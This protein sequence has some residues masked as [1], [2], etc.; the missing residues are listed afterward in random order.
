[1]NVGELYFEMGTRGDI[2]RE[3]DQAETAATNLA[4]QAGR[5]EQALANIAAPESLRR[6]IMQA[7]DAVGQLSTSAGTART[8]IRQLSGSFDSAARREARQTADAVEQVAR[9][10]QSA[11]GE[12]RQLTGS[13]A[14]AEQRAAGVGNAF[15]ESMEG[16]GEAG[17][18]GGAAGGGG[19]IAMFASK[20]KGAAGKGG[21]IAAAVTA[22]VAVGVVA[23]QKLADAVQEG[24]ALQAERDF[25]QASFGFTDAQMDQAGKAA[26]DAFGNAFGTSVNENI[27]T[28]GIAI[29]AGIL[30]GDATAAEMQPIIEQL[31]FTSELM[32]EEIPAV[33]KA[34]GQWIRTGLVKNGVEAFDL[35]TAAQQRGLNLSEDILDTMNEYGTHFRKAGIDGATAMGL[36]AQAV[37]GGARDTDI[38]ADAIKEFALRVIDTGEATTEALGAM[39]GTIGM[40]VEEIQGEFAK[41][42]EAAFNMTDKILD[43]LGEL[44][45]EVDKNA[46]AIALFGTQYEDLG[47]AFDEF[48]LTTARDE[49]DASGKSLEAMGTAGGGAA[50]SIQGAKS[51]I[52]V[53][54]DEMKIKLGEA[55]AP[56]AGDAANWVTEHEGEILQFLATVATTAL[57][58]TAGLLDAG[59]AALQFGALAYSA[60]LEI[61]DG[62]VGP[63]T[64]MMESLGGVLKHVPGM[65]SVGGAMEDTARKTRGLVEGMRDG[66]DK[67][68]DAGGA[69]FTLADKVRDGKATIEDYALA[70]QEAAAGTDV[71]KQEVADLSYEL[72][73]LPR[74]HNI[75]MDAPG[76][77]AVVD[78]LTGLGVQV[79]TDNRKEVEVI[80]PLAPGV[81]DL[82]KQLGVEVVS[83]NGKDILVTT[84]APAAKTEVDALNQSIDNMTT[85]KQVLFDLVLNKPPAPYTGT[86]NGAT[87]GVLGAFPNANRWGSIRGVQQFKDGG[88]TAD[89]MKKP[90][91][92]DIYQPRPGHVSIFN[93]ESTKGETYLPWDQAARARSIAIMKATAQAWGLDVVPAGMV[94]GP[95][96][97]GVRADGAI[98]TPSQV[99]GA[100]GGLSSGVYSFGGW[101]GTWNTDCSGAQAKAANW[102]TAG[103]TEAGGRFATGNMAEALGARGYTAGQAPAGVPAIEH[104]WYNGGEGGGHAA[105]TVYDP[106][107]GDTDFEMGG[108][109]GNGAVGAGASGSREIGADN[110]A[111][112]PLGSEDPRATGGGSM[113]TQSQVGGGASS[114]PKIGVNG[115]SDSGAALNVNVM[116]WPA[117]LTGGGAKA[118]LGVAMYNTGGTIAG[119]GDS[120]TELFLGTPGEEIIAKGPASKPGMRAH[121]KAI[122]SG[123]VSM[124]STGGTVGGFGGYTSS[125]AEHHKDWNLYDLLAAGTG[126]AFTA[127]SAVNVQ[128]GQLKGFNGF[129]TGST[130]IPGSDDLYKLLKEQAEKPTIVIEHAEINADSPQELA[131]SLLAINPATAEMTKRGIL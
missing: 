26:G 34:A 72:N 47:A 58:V 119:A 60:G 63:L 64:T 28:A 50:A 21:P 48:D 31:Q 37:E 121:L 127:A 54:A 49:M 4:R 41:G 56:M 36:I 125:G 15:R 20:L 14:T 109:S 45:P 40:S 11:V 13:F 62:F 74:E 111:W 39:S 108:S 94:G 129:S 96:D 7:D 89:W 16:A 67:M 57:E 112:K 53:A 76:G 105:G 42:G 61:L 93:E 100:I 88:I 98:V 114:A 83:N 120:D 90:K 126:A 55:F 59:G 2:N 32:G 77:Q 113:G 71:T 82:L 104:G 115:D 101:D 95:N 17:E 33:A 86:G 78:L 6:D 110:F 130:S 25:S 27:N 68:H 12:V 65:K 1:M 73:K 23:G 8:D 84:N 106:A 79:N 91:S 3:L 122:N 117:E 70:Q 102:V 124:F 52:T 107:Q 99:V 75:D 43:A 24:F 69:M 80:S 9:E 22:V 10:A 87:D 81:I 123:K 131:D 38:A 85:T 46:I 103:D 30:D 35:M 116:N 92:A 44:P 29:Q 118:R 51:K 128:D 18:E 5:T 19:F 66:A 97:V